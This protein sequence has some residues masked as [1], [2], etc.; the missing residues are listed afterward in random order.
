MA[1][2]DQ[3]FDY[4]CPLAVLV[5]MSLLSAFLIFAIGFVW[6]SALFTD[7]KINGRIAP[8]EDR[9]FISLAATAGLGVFIYISGKTVLRHF[10]ETIA[11]LGSEVIWTD[12]IGRV[13]M[14]IHESEIT[15]QGKRPL[16]VNGVER[17][18]IHSLRGEIHFLSTIS[19]RLELV[20]RVDAI[21]NGDRK[22]A[23]LQETQARVWQGAPVYSYRAA[24]T[25][26]PAI[27]LTGFLLLLV[28]LLPSSAPA[29]TLVLPAGILVLPAGYFLLIFLF[30]KIEIKD[31]QL[32]YFGKSGKVKMRVPLIDIESVDEQRDDVSLG[33]IYTKQGEIR[34]TSYLLRYDDFMANMRR[35][36][37]LSGETDRLSW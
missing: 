19:R 31:G 7:M 21:L 1:V 9:L 26:I 11:F 37:G 23:S 32:V 20:R 15:G 6:Y 24:L 33:R 8:E 2:R 30:E 16:F 14:R 13:R 29:L 25:L 12:S 35:L 5:I 18:R 17:H 34:V 4:R 3:V 10:N 36:T 28:S 27:V 22:Q